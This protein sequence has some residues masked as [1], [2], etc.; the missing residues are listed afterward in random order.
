MQNYLD[1]SNRRFYT[2]RGIPYRR[3]YLLHGP[4][5][6]GKTSLSLVLAGFFGLE[7][8]LVH[9]PTVQSDY[10]L[11]A[12]FASLPPSCIVPLE[13]IDAVGLKRESAKAVNDENT[14]VVTKKVIKRKPPRSSCTLS[15]LLNIIDGVASQEGKRIPL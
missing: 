2:A 6:T 4:P 12:L 3:E 11:Q 13:D 9:V 7:L 8:Y 14:D 15:G 10:A 1:A 5:G